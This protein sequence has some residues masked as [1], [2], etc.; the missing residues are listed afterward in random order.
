MP[1]VANPSSLGRSRPLLGLRHRPGRLALCALPDA[2]PGLPPWEGVDPGPHVPAVD[3]CRTEDR[4]SHETV[5]M[6]LRYRPE[7]HEAVICS[8]WGPDTDWMRNIRA[9]P[10]IRVEIGREVVH[11][12][13]AIPLRGREPRRGGRV[14]SPAPLAVPL[15]VLGPRLGR[16]PRRDDRPGLRATPGRSS[17]SSGRSPEGGVGGD[18]VHGWAQASTRHRSCGPSRRAAGPGRSS[19][20][21]PSTPCRSRR[22]ATTSS[23]SGCSTRDRRAGCSA[24]RVSPRSSRPPRSRAARPSIRPPPSPAS[25]LTSRSPRPAGPIGCS[26]TPG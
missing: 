20:S 25:R 19:R 9:H 26:S 7:T 15:H 13:A 2:A 4:P 1:D 12:R 5:A 8:A 6:V 14:P 23:T 10:A 16:P 22:C 11:P 21:N 24:G 3:P 17:P 18:H